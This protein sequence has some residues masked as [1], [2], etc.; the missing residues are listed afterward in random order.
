MSN[1]LCSRFEYHRAFQIMKKLLLFLFISF[2]CVGLCYAQRKSTTT[3]D[4]NIAVPDTVLIRTDRGNTITSRFYVIKGKDL[5]RID[6]YS[7]SE[8]CDT[9]FFEGLDEDDKRRYNHEVYL[10]NLRS[11]PIEQINDREA[12]SYFEIGDSIQYFTS[13]LGSKKVHVSYTGYQ[14][15]FPDEFTKKP[16]VIEFCFYDGILKKIERITSVKLIANK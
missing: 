16:Q 10:I 8:K 11:K 15:T 4:S 5:I 7:N 1:I 3:L 14:L 12:F 2:F 6:Q 13:R 9:T